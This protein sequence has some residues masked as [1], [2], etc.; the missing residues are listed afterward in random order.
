VRGSEVDGD[1]LLAAA[2]KRNP[3]VAHP[4]EPLRTVVYRMAETGLTRFPVVERDDRRKLVGIIALTDLL[5]A[6]VRNLEA[7]RRRER[8][9]PLRL[10]LPWRARRR[11]K[12]GRYDGNLSAG[13]DSI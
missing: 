10:V 6:R 9:L 3:V 8:I 12:A 13:R 1:A 7:E 5:E 2:V 11:K 4:E